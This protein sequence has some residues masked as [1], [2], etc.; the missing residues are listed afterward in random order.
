MTTD[1]DCISTIGVCISYFDSIITELKGFNF[2]EL[3]NDNKINAFLNLKLNLITQICIYL[4]SIRFEKTLC[5]NE[6]DKNVLV[7]LYPAFY[8]Q[9][10]PRV[11][12]GDGNCLWNMISL[13]L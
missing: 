12:I 10:Q 4:N 7:H 2:Q 11:T 3:L 6:I 9:Y 8:S 1:E 5:S 13:A